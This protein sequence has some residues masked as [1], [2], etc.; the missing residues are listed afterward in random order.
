MLQAVKARDLPDL[1]TFPVFCTCSPLTH[2]VK[3]FIFQLLRTSRTCRPT[4]PEQV[5]RAW[6]LPDLLPSFA[7]PF[8]LRYT[9][10]HSVKSFVLQL[11]RTSRTCR[12]T[13]P[14][15]RAAK[16]RGAS[17]SSW[18]TRGSSWTRT[19]SALNP[20]PC[21]AGAR[22]LQYIVPCQKKK[23]SLGRAR[24]SRD[25]LMESCLRRHASGTLPPQRGGPS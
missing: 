5:V 10:T 15:P 6:G 17:L 13:A 24:R 12:P 2:S 4:A 3:S 16:A 21:S 11:L 14:E 23:K 7:L 25:G 20:T 8:L 18:T 1:S 22:S 19:C 9:L